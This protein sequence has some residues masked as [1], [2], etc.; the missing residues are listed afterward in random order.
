MFITLEADNTIS[1]EFQIY[2]KKRKEDVTNVV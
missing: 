1:P 2:S